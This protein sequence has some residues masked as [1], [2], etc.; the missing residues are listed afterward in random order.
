M[1]IL[2][3]TAKLSSKGQLTLPKCARDSLGTEYVHIIVDENG[4]RLEPVADLAASLRGYAR[5]NSNPKKTREKAWEEAV[6]E[7]HG[8][9]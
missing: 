2:E 3:S 4:I 9:D 8:R 7:K 5:S 1:V 6:N